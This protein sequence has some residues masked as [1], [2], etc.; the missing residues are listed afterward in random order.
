M[1]KPTC[2]AVMGFGEKT[3]FQTGRKLDLDKTYHNIIKPAVEDAGYDCVRADEIQHSGVID[4]PMYE[5]LFAADLVVADLSTSNLNAVFELGVRHA[6]KPRST[7]IIAESQFKSPFDINHILIRSYTHLGVDIGFSEVMRMREQLKAIA[8]ALKDGSATDSPVYSLLPWLR[9]PTREEQKAAL[10]AV[11]ASQAAAVD[12]SETYSAMWKLALDAKS[13][14]NFEVAK[15]TLRKIYDAQSD[16]HGQAKLPRPRVIQELALATYK[17]GDSAAPAAAKAAY[18]EAAQL[19]QQLDPDVTNDPETLGLWCGLHKRMANLADLSPD[20]RKTHLDIAILAAER[21]FLIRADFY[22]GTNL[23]YLLNIR[24]SLS[25]GDDRIADNVLAARVRRQV[26]RI[27]APQT[28]EQ[29]DKVST[30]ALLEERYW[31]GASLAEALVGLGD[32]KGNALLEQVLASAPEPWMADTTR[33]QIGE[34]K[35][36][37]AKA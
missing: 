10:A 33:K 29:G 11:A 17:S 23:A 5:Q 7:I 1:P 28:R 16:S 30:P 22:T 36:L 27:C 35:A 2:F 18:T 8:L 37:L 24:A 6:L 34:L 25:D 12:D 4:I 20:E 3:D 15:F 21:G 26:A 19:L 31:A 32:A 9:Q 13:Q 14:G